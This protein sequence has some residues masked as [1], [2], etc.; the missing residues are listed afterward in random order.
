MGAIITAAKRAGNALLD[1]FFPRRCVYCGAVNSPGRY[2]F[3]CA[4]CERDIY[5]IKGGRC[6]RCSEI[7]GTNE[8]PNSA[9]CPKCAKNPPAFNWSMACCVFSGP[10]RELALGL[11]YRNSPH[12]AADV[13][14]IM[15]ETPGLGEFLKDSV[16]IP[17]PLH[18]ARKMKRGYNQSEIIADAAKRAFPRAGM[19]ISNALRRIKRTG[20]QTHLTREERSENIRGAFE[21]QKG[22]TSKIPKGAHIVIVDDVMT[23]GA[24]MSECAKILKEEGFKNVDAFAFARKM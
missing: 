22:K 13:A 23:S 21:A 10:A 9:F 3:V 19:T 14:K 18:F 24:T 12:L 7:I 1:M 2:D 6:L 8:A 11:K 20:T 4:D 5:I 15:A 16:L 17:V